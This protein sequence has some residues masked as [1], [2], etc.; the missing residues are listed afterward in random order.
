MDA[1]AHEH[2]AKHNMVVVGENEIFASHLVYKVPHNYQVLLEI[3]LSG[4]THAKYLA[5]RRE[6]PNSLM[7]LLLDSMD[8][9]KIQSAET[10]TGTLYVEDPDGE[11]REVDARVR[12]GKDRFRVL[13]FDR[14]PE[15]L[16]GSH[17]G[18]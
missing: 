11:R 6:N 4:E 8:I 14:V 2:H 7:I 5:A 12:L 17:L 1:W 13:Y 10:L 15:S 3:H 18:E 9:S 16:V